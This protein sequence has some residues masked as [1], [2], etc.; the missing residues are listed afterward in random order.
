MDF[1]FLPL[2]LPNKGMK[3]YSKIIL[4]IH[5]HSISFPPPKRDL[6]IM[7][8]NLPPIVL[9]LIFASLI[10]HHR[11]ANVNLWSPSAMT[12]TYQ[13]P[14]CRCIQ[15]SILMV[16]FFT[17][18]YYILVIIF[19]LDYLTFLFFLFSNFA[20]KGKKNYAKET[21]TRISITS[22]FF[23]QHWYRVLFSHLYYV[24]THIYNKNNNVEV[25]FC[26]YLF[27]LILYFSN[28]YNNGEKRFES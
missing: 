18:N 7:K 3:E 8:E 20:I 1:P 19:I 24:N 12:T 21:V 4:F 15:L 10:L 28:C 25:L 6:S 22:S 11:L 17:R 9:F 23:F 2:K 13:L 5:F 26:F 14:I 27:F 16:I